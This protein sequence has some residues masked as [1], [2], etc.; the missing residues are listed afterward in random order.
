MLLD[1]IQTSGDI[2]TLARFGRA[3]RMILAC[4]AEGDK[5]CVVRHLSGCYCGVGFKPVY[6][7]V[8][9]DKLHGSRCVRCPQL[10]KIIENNLS[11]LIVVWY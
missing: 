9:C 7:E 2:G 6:M 5:V 11:Y 4:K 10:L 8:V 3:C 1:I